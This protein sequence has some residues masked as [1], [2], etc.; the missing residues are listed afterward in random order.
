MTD[1]RITK[2]CACGCGARVSNIKNT[3]I[4]GHQRKSSTV[5]ANADI[6]YRYDVYL[7][8]P[9]HFNFIWKRD[10]VYLLSKILR[11]MPK[12]NL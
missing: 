5:D 10:V 2:R 9:D 4:L 6:E 7:N 8:N 11:E 1:D 12:N 3:Y